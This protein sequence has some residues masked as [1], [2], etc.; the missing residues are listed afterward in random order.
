MAVPLAAFQVAVPRLQEIYNRITGAQPYNLEVKP[1]SGTDVYYTDGDAQYW[2]G[3]IVF[4][5]PKTNLDDKQYYFTESGIVRVLR[6]SSL[7]PLNEW[8]KTVVDSYKDQ[9]KQTSQS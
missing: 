8:I 3:K 4:M 9:S 1:I 5:N 7:D 2:T 6:S